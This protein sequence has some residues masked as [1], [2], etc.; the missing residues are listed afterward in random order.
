VE[1]DVHQT[2]SA[3]ILDLTANAVSDPRNT[4]KDVT[5]IVFERLGFL[6]RSVRIRGEFGSGEKNVD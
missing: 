2:S 6:A 3:F 5:R 4:V 1:P